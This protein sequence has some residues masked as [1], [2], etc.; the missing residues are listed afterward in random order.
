MESAGIPGYVL[1]VVSAGD[2]DRV[3]EVIALDG[4]V[5]IGRDPGCTV[6]FDDQS[7][8]R[9][10]AR[11][12]LTPDGVRVTDLGSGNGVWAG[13]RRV[14]EVLLQEGD[15]L[16]LGS[17]TLACT[18][19]GGRL[20]AREQ[21]PQSET[22]L[23]EAPP[24]ASAGATED[25]GFVV[26]FRKSSSGE[27]W[28]DAPVTGSVAV[29]GR[30]PDCSV[31][32]ADRTVSRRH[33]RVEHGSDGFRITHLGGLAGLWV[34]GR[35]VGEAVLQSGQAF[36]LGRGYLV[37]C[38]RSAP[39][40]EYEVAQVA[41]PFERDKPLTQPVA[42]EMEQRRAPATAGPSG[43]PDEG[44]TLQMR[45]GPDFDPSKTLEATGELVAVNSHQPLVLDAPDSAYY[46]VSGGLELFTVPLDQGK[47]TGTREHFLSL[48]S[49]HCCFGFDPA[50]WG[51][52]SGFLA[53]GRQDTV[54]RRVK[55]QDLER[56]G[57][58]RRM[59]ALV[60][61]LVDVW[62]TGM[63]ASLS[64]RLTTAG[65]KD[66][67]LVEGETV[68][69]GVGATATSAEGV[70]WVDV[71]GGSVLFNDLLTPQFKGSHGLIPL[72]SDAW[73]ESVSGEFGDM[74]LAPVRTGA[75]LENDSLWSAFLFFQQLFCE[76]E[77]LTKRLSTVDEYVRLQH[78]AEASRETERA[79]YDRIGS[80]LSSD[81]STPEEFLSASETEPVVNACRIVGG[82]VG[83]EVTSHLS[84]DETLTYEEK[85]AAVANAS[86]FRVR[87][88]AL[89]DAW[90][91]RDS[92]P[93]L[94]QMA[95]THV[96][97]ALIPQ[98]PR[99]Y[100]LIDPTTRASIPVDARVASS[101]LAFGHE[102]YRPFPDGELQVIDLMR[103]GLRGLGRDL[104][105]LI[106]LGILMGVLGTFT[107]FVTG[108]IFDETIP[109]ADRPL[110][111]T[112]CIGLVAAGV[113][114]S[115]YQIVQ[116]IAVV[117]VQ[118][119]MEYG[120]QSALWDRLLKLPVGFFR[121]YSAG[122]LAERAAGVNEIQ[123][124]VSG[125]AV[126]AILGVLSG[127]G[128]FVQML[129]FGF[130]LAATAVGL[131]L[132]FVVFTTS[133]SYLQL[134]YQRREI[135]LSGEISGLV[136][137][138]ITGVTKIRLCGAEQHAFRV[139]AQRFADQCKIGFRLGRIQNISSVFIAS[140]SVLSSMA[141][142]GVMFMLQ[143]S[144]IA[145][146]RPGISM[147]EFIAFS[148]AYG[149][150]L[151]AMQALGDASL[152]LLAVVPLYERLKPI[153]TTPAEVDGAKAYP[154]R[155]NGEISLSHVSFRYTDDGPWVM[156]DVSL[157]I[158]PGEFVAFVGASGCGKSTLMRV[159]LGFEVP[160]KGAVYYD[161]QDLSALDVRLVRQ[162]MGVVLQVS[163][164]MPT[165][166]YRNIVGMSSRTIQDAWVA[167]E[168]AGLAEDIRQ[169]PM[170]MHTWVA[171]GGG[172]LSG[173]QRQRL[174][175]ARA[176]VNSPKVLFLD[177][178][179]SALDN[180]TQAIVT[181]S[182]RRMAA[183][184]IVIAH[185][186]ST[187]VHADRICYLEKGRI[188]ES[189]TYDELMAKKGLFAKLAER[190]MA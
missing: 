42:R 133:M 173:G 47:P 46:V 154:G 56:L 141:I 187:I 48:D 140:F 168:M 86:G 80:V 21:S 13:G 62:I 169:M 7:L 30:A 22:V 115:V 49:G 16:R 159:L 71:W 190:Q 11:L 117:R 38:H 59:R 111:W 150:F 118:G 137:N 157:E 82:V 145:E 120:I 114:R 151:A 123:S 4:E 128:Y 178:A 138:L 58:S 28:T 153:V 106:V 139:W 66:V 67:S 53:V 84:D 43:V 79:A 51:Q 131:T 55:V 78:K 165:E 130:P 41:G 29:L 189:G 116:G 39:F 93:F 85:I 95:D 136:F 135:E 98:S 24:R 68:R 188:A 87:V 112:F 174:L 26:R 91:T 166:L 40:D 102:F 65:D 89:R 171:E 161:G 155:L 45:A 104:R 107:P 1:R 143:Q 125:A 70:V 12:K 101:L 119:K 108:Q 105:L 132:I 2:R 73:I 64:R 181:E 32:I 147:G 126:G 33:V 77:F 17:T 186:L 8:S 100:A 31:V 19:D 99:S 121:K 36:G 57:R 6:T 183:T 96:P 50:R 144:A 162:Q 182:M 177:E 60:A 88:V 76:C 167:A 23:L 74:P 110:L 103:F 127:V 160:N 142:F 83:M 69:L 180:Q 184:R 44:Q 164:V 146:G 5:T 90:W 14:A 35:Q 3:G 113:V 92:G 185:R 148:T 176:L 27:A 129:T 75:L 81:A 63:L 172:T 122:D 20:F 61:T 54:L 10:H 94:G 97:V 156:D 175:I 109:Q 152:S 25:A 72:S 9:R 149:L 15:E 179:T 163:R 158:K 18:L 52:G 124:L 34:D 37:E 134:R 170:G